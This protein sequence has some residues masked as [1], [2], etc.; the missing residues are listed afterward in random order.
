MISDRALRGNQ[1]EENIY[2]FDA[3]PHATIQ[4]PVYFYFYQLIKNL[5]KIFDSITSKFC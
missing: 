5:L 1:S 2:W 3:S 4:K